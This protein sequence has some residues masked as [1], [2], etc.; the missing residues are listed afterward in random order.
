VLPFWV[1]LLF[2]WA[3]FSSCIY[4]DISVVIAVAAAL[5]LSEEIAKD[6]SELE[7]SASIVCTTTRHSSTSVWSARATCKLSP[8]SIFGEVS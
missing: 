1:L 5:I 3:R 6:T 4:A 8:S 2:A 7:K